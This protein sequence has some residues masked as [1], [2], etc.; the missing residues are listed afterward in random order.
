MCEFSR[1]DMCDPSESELIESNGQF[2]D[3]VKG[4]V[5]D[6]KLTRVARQEELQVFRD[7]RV[8]DVIDRASLPRNAKLVGVRW[9]DTNKGTTA[10]PR[11]RSRLVCREFNFGGD[12]TGEMFAPTPP[13]AAT[14]YLLSR[15][16]SRGARGPGAYRTML[17]D[18]KRAFLYGDVEREIFIH[19]P[20]EDSRRNGGQRVGVLRKAMYGTRDAPAVWQRLVRRVMVELGF[21]FSRTAACVYVHR[22]RGLRVV[23]HVD[24]FLVTGPKAE[25]VELRRQLQEGYE[26]DG[27][28][29]GLEADEKSE[30]KFLGRRIVHQP[31]GIEV[32]GDNKLVKGL[33]E[34]YGSAGRRAETPGTKEEAES[35]GEPMEGSEAARFRRGAAKVNYLAQDR[36]DLAYASKEV[37]RHMARPEKGDERKLLRIV[38]YIREHP[39][40]LSTY[41]WQEA[42]G[43]FTTFTDSD[44]GGCTRTRRSTSGGVILHGSHALLHW[45]R[46]QQLIALS[47][48]EA[49]LNAAIKAGQEGL[50]LKHLAEELGDT[51]WV[52]VLG[53]SSAADGIVKRSG[54]GKVKHLSV[55]QLWL[56]E[57]VGQGELEH[58]KIPRLDNV[59]DALTHHFTKAEGY[60]H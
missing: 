42:P 31:W 34:E 45:S 38:S 27:D 49:E 14:R 30:G 48:A 6:E 24:D 39:R 51:C 36:A 56:Q 2:V 18:F 32:E 59:A 57:K 54:T 58:E 28:I 20:E 40:W 35:S 5:L 4:D 21:E 16:A 41:R 22:A 1:P 17:L 19:L 55:R 53:D 37:S 12:P 44:W 33:L 43:G 47:S 46:T 52:Q 25:L 7:R 13:L 3:D 26:V 60:L 29:L 15:I 11:I 50:A 10:E 23:A 8:Y 9:V